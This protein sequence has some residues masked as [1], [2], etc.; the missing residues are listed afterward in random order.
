M[1]RAITLAYVFQ[2]FKITPVNQQQLFNE[3]QERSTRNLWDGKSDS[4]GEIIALLHV[5]LLHLLLMKQGHF[6]CFCI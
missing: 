6:L 4:Y 2:T 1:C 3:T 5:G